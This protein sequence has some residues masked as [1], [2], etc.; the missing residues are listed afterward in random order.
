MTLNNTRVLAIG[1]CVLVLVVMAVFAYVPAGKRELGF[2]MISRSTKTR[3]TPLADAMSPQRPTGRF[4]LFA[5]GEDEAPHPRGKAEDEASELAQ[6]LA[7]VREKLVALVQYKKKYFPDTDGLHGWFRDDE[8]G[9]AMDALAKEFNGLAW[10]SGELFVAFLQMLLREKDRDFLLVAAQYLTRAYA[11]RESIFS[12][13]QMDLLIEMLLVIDDEVGRFLVAKGIAQH[14]NDLRLQHGDTSADASCVVVGPASACALV[15]FIRDCLATDVTSTYT[16]NTCCSLIPL[17]GRYH[18]F[19]HEVRAFLLGM[20]RDDTLALTI[21]LQTLRTF[22]FHTP[23]EDTEIFALALS[24]LRDCRYPELQAVVAADFFRC[25]DANRSSNVDVFYSTLTETFNHSTN[26]SLRQGIARRLAFS[27]HPT[28]L[29]WTA[30]AFR[31]SDI[32]WDLKEDMF[33]Q[34][35][36]KALSGSDYRGG[37]PADQRA[38]IYQELKDLAL[39]SK[40][41]ESIRAQAFFTAMSLLVNEKVVRGEKDQSAIDCYSD[42]LLLMKNDKSQVIRDKAAQIEQ[43]LSDY[44]EKGTPIDF[45]TGATMSWD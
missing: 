30:G 37:F 18:R 40:H 24:I 21:R 9:R 41:E 4:E 7:G 15:S 1:L 25:D 2:E 28:A 3:N 26:G 22:A 31:S 34:T 20:A 38:W 32:P 8:E 29:E 17:L 33:K 6:R 43:M 12:R 13:E 45:D 23:T 16:R 27:N 5:P 44:L 19:Y 35:R 39:S 11:R 10:S 14:V 42:L 36:Q